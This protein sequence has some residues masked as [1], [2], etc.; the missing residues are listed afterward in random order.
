MGI[1]WIDKFVNGIWGGTT[2]QWVWFKG[3]IYRKTRFYPNLLGRGR[4]SLKSILGCTGWN[5]QPNPAQK[6]MQ[7]Y[8]MFDHHPIF[9]DGPEM[10]RYKKPPISQLHSPYFDIFSGSN[11]CNNSPWFPANVPDL[12]HWHPEKCATCDAGPS[13]GS[14]PWY[15]GELIWFIPRNMV[16][17]SS[18][19]ANITHI[20]IL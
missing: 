19:E 16:F 6:Y 9:G 10:N 15:H 4:F 14:T 7:H 18:I 1:S 8:S 20:Y 17:Y 11:P 5:R 12:S 3:K 2:N 13:N